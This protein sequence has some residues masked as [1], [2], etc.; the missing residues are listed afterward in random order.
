MFL[1][2]PKDTAK[3]GWFLLAG[4]GIKAQICSLVELLATTLNQ[5]H[6]LFY[7]LPEGL[8]PDPLLPCGLLFSTLDS[9]TS[10]H[11]SGELLASLF[12]FLVHSF[13]RHL[14][15]ATLGPGD[16]AVDWTDTDPLSWRSQSRGRGRC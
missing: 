4:A 5:A 7:T 12:C 11:P 15:A 13:T 6:A 9:I 14:P 16:T 8:L 2:L 3:R 10:Q 1:T